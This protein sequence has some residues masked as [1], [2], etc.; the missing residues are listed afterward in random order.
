VGFFPGYLTPPGPVSFGFG[1]HD[2]SGYRWS[3]QVSVPIVGAPEQFVYLPPGALGNG[4]SFH[5][6]FAPGMILSVFGSN[7]TNPYNTSGQAGSLPLPLTLA[8]SSAKINGVPAPYYYA[9]NGQLNIQI[10]YETAPGL[11]V[12]TVTGVYGQ[13]FNYSFNVQPSAPGIFTGPGNTAVPFA[14]GSRGGTYTL[15]ITGEGQVT[16]ALA[17]GG[18]PDPSTP[19]TNLPHPVLPVSMTIGGENTPIA[20]IGIPS[21]LAGVTQV[22]FTVPRDAPLGTQPVVVTVGNVASPPVNFTVNP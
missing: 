11:A 8:G 17:T 13:T 3:T 16:P 5:E 6:V 2:T 22:N 1:G 9:S 14:S 7:L 18:T 20:F 10:P 15:F 19:Y 12:L 4:A 21:G